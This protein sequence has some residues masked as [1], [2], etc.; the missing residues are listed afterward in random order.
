MKIAI[1]DDEQEFALILKEKLIKFYPSAQID[2]FASA[3]LEFYQNQYDIVFLDVMLGLDKSFEYGEKILEF[4]PDTVLV[5]ISSL[6]D[7]VYDSYKQESF[8]F[9]RKEKLH[10]DLTAF[11][12]KYTKSI[13][14]S[15][16]TITISYANQNIELLQHDIIYITSNKNKI[17]IYTQK[18]IYSIYMSLKKVM[19]LLD[20]KYFYRLNSFTIINFDHILNF[21]KKRILMSNGDK[22]K[23]T[24]N[25]EVPFVNAYLRYRGNKIWNG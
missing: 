22:L 17:N 14:H 5:Y 1:I 6:N 18:S 12:K 4:C 19:V 13:S 21:D 24:R 11:Y 10:D 25:S 7:F 8:F 9:V 20:E 23:F 16:A 2:I 15:S 3:Y